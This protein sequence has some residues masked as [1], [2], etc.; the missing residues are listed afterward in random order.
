MACIVG[1]IP[2]AVRLSTLHADAAV[3]HSPLLPARLHGIRNLIH[4][5][6]DAC[7]LRVDL[8]D[9]IVL[10]L[11]ELLD[12]TS[13]FSQLFEH[14][15]LARGNSMH[16]PKAEHPAAGVDHSEPLKGCSIHHSQD[17]LAI[18]GELDFFGHSFRAIDSI[19]MGAQ[20][21]NRLFR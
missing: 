8:L 6:F 13:L 7:D 10:H 20:L 12:S 9:E 3:S 18:V 16:P 1:N 15:I 5:V 11:G 21:S 4:I 2:S 17:R 19:L 14:S